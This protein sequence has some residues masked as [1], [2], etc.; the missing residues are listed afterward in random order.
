VSGDWSRTGERSNLLAVRLMAWIAVTLG[1]RL[2]R[3]MLHP[4]ALYFVLFSP[5]ARRHSARYL[6]R[7]L[8][9]P[10]RFA[11]L[12]RHVHT[13]ASTVLDRVYLVRGQMQLFDIGLHGAELLEAKIADGRG[14]VLLG[15]HIGSFEVLHATGKNQHGLRVA[16]VM[17]PDN[18]RMI[19][20]VLQGIAPD[21]RLG[22]IPIGRSGS[23]LAIRDWLDAGGLAGMLGD[24]FPPSESGRVGTLSVPF[25]GAPAHFSVGPLRLAMLLRRSVIFMTG[26]YRGGNRYDVSFTPLAD[27]SQVGPSPAERD[28]ALHAAMHAYVARLEALC[29]E[30]PYNWF[31]FHDFWREDEP[32]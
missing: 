22:V 21:F 31:N 23:T 6:R 30:A 7:A 18:A 2:T 14:A 20:S 19:H 9:R 10:A 26:L 1:R 24:R 4:I 17:Y 3:L 15:A 16:M 27:F 13:F 25:L 11:D 29:R 8:G 5:A 28:A 32:A 12:Y